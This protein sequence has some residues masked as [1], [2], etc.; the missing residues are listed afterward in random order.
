MN[1]TIKKQLEHKTIREFKDIVIDSNTLKNLYDVA[2]RTPTSI[3]MQSFS[4]IRVVDKEKRRAISEVCKQDYVRTAPELFIFIVDIFRNSKVAEEMG[5]N[6][7]NAGNMDK[8]FQGVTDAILA[9]QNT[10]TAIESLDLGGVFLGSI[11]NDS[12]KMIEILE[13]PKLTFP[14][15]GLAFGYPNQEP[16]LKPRMDI[17]LK[18]FEDRYMIQDSYLDKIKNY[19]EEMKKYYDL[20]DTSKPLNSFS[21]QV[22]SFLSS[23]N[24]N[25]VR[26]LH[27]AKKQGFYIL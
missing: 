16:Q 10:Y 8:F 14:I 4:L 18:V 27:V 6:I 15:L 12:E 19:D 5:G 21:K 1:K 22:V 7:D 17:S 3:G 2:N 26:I 11:L 9:A 13:L 20:R 24:E 23:Y 25:R